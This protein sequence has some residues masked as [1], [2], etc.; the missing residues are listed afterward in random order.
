MKMMIIMLSL[1]VLAGCG[2][3]DEEKVLLKQSSLETTETIVYKNHIVRKHYQIID[4]PSVNVL[5]SPQTPETVSPQETEPQQ[6]QGG[7]TANKNSFT[8]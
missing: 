4:T 8:Q 3:R 7:N 1:C 2:T 5:V 6:R